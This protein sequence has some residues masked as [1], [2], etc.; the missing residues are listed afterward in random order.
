MEGKLT[1]LDGQHRVGMM[2]ILQ[3]KKTE[4]SFDL[5]RIL[6]EVFPEVDKEKYETYAQ[7][8]FTEINKAEPVKLVDMPG[9]A[10]VTDRKV[11]TEGASRLKERFPDMFKPSQQ[12]RAPHL[13]I[14]NLRDALFASDIIKRHKLKSPKALENWMVEQN[15]VLRQQFQEEE[16][17]SKVSKTA[18]QKANKFDFF[19][20]LDSSWLYN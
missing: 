18:L 8:I 13:N 5:D 11:I 20:G 3:E 16:H 14:D 9:V 7:D 2:T 12:C 1:I 19:L 17:A 15:D 4:V 10:S 6:V